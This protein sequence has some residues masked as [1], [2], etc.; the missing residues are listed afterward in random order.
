MVRCSGFDDQIVT[1]ASLTER[2][3][4]LGKH[5]EIRERESRHWRDLTARMTLIYG[6]CL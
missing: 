3:R 6:V 4:W 2:E 5:G 1:E